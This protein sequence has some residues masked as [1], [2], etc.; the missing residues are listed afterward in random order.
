MRTLIAAL[1][2]TVGINSFAVSPKPGLRIHIWHCSSVAAGP[3]HGTSIHIDHIAAGGTQATVST[4]SIMGPQKLGQYQVTSPLASRG[5]TVY[6]DIQTQGSLFTLS[7]NPSGAGTF[8]A[9][10]NRGQ[11]ARGAVRCFRTRGL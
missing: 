10:G 2:L 6:R 3:D 9:V 8:R 5:N 1:A 11:G 7:I 4:Q